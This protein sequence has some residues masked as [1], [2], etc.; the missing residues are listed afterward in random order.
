MRFTQQILCF[1]AWFHTSC[2]LWPFQTNFHG[3][4]T[5]YMCFGTP[6]AFLDGIYLLLIVIGLN[7]L[8]V[9]NSYLNKFDI[10]LTIF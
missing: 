2:A 1:V 6:Y 4:F 7:L 10:I 8:S 5:Y 3:K 9:F